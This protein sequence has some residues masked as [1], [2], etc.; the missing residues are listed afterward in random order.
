MPNEPPP[1]PRPAVVGD[2]PAETLLE[3]AQAT[4]A[5]G[6]LAAAREQF[7]AA[8]DAAERAGDAIALAEAAIG[9]GGLWLYELRIADER[10]AYLALARD[11]LEHLTE[12][13]RIDLRL[14]LR[15]RLAAE[16]IYDGSS[17]LEDPASDRRRCSRQ[18]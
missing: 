13:D 8:A 6:R 14:R 7:L 4:L 9:A 10:A 2:E 18:R 3:R 1:L 11:A 12:G 17:T 15:A 16:A 5:A